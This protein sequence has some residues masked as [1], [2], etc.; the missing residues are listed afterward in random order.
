MRDKVIKITMVI[1]I[2][3]FFCL[4]K[5]VSAKSSDISSENNYYELDQN[6][7]EDILYRNLS[8]IIDQEC[9][10]LEGSWQVAVDSLDDKLS[11]DLYKSSTDNLDSL[12][13]ASTIKI[14]VGLA[15]YKH[16]E[17]GKLDESEIYD[18]VYS[19]LE[20]SNNE[21]CNRLIDLLGF[22]SINET[23]FDITGRN[24]TALN[25]KM[26]HDGVENLANAKDL[27]MALV[28]LDKATYISR[29]NSDKLLNALANNTTTSYTKLLANL[30]E[31]VTGLN[32]SGELS[33]RGV[34]N[35]I[36]II[37]TENFKFAISVLSDYHRPT[38]NS[39]S[40]Q[41]KVLRNLGRKIS[42]EFIRY[43]E[44]YNDNEVSNNPSS[45]TVNSS[46]N[47]DYKSN[48]NLDY[49]FKSPVEKKSKNKSKKSSLNTKRNLS[50]ILLIGFL[51]IFAVFIK[52]NK[53]K[54]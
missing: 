41:F 53:N 8:K 37:K 32:K 50:L 4:S 20:N 40:P 29:D 1:V 14:F 5:P 45:K 16:V 46:I 9:Q 11:L 21:S 49:R 13:S 52:F 47:K 39:D 48:D 18:D 7:K 27:N 10:N 19:M 12:T 6:D 35:D 44:N 43:D 2:F 51:I 42:E 25:R 23:I 31:G 15:A 17:E 33:D 3:T 34:Q 28:S 24:L 26:L 38:P 22:D 30:P 36:A 54:F